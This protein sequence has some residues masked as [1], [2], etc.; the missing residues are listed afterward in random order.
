MV[1]LGGG[2]LRNTPVQLVSSSSV[3]ASGH[4]CIVCHFVD[5]YVYL[6]LGLIAKG[7]RI[8]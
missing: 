4:F 1:F 7:G 5:D 8:C 6:H 2:F 3:E